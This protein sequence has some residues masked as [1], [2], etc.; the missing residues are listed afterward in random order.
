MILFFTCLVRTSGECSLSGESRFD[1]TRLWKYGGLITAVVLLGSGWWFVRT[2][3]VLNGDFL[4]LKTREEMVAVYGLPQF[5]YTETFAGRGSSFFEMIV[6]MIKNRLPVRL[7]ESLI[8]AYG[9]LNIRPGIWFYALYLLIWATGTAGAVLLLVRRLRDR[10]NPV[11][12]RQWIFH[13]CMLLCIAMPLILYLRYCYTIDYQEQGRYLLPALIPAMM[14][15]S[16][17][18]SRFNKWVVRSSIAVIVFCAVWQVFA[19]ALPAFGVL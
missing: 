14:Y 16:K 17:G 1:M 8:A 18:L 4:G 13:G 10:T 11:G 6:L 5:Q 15:V 12:W 19:V 7:T 3:I 9:M 2:A